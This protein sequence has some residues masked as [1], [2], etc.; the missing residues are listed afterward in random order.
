MFIYKMLLSIINGWEG[1]GKV[2]FLA[3]GVMVYERGNFMAVKQTL[4]SAHR[5]ARGGSLSIASCSKPWK[6]QRG[7]T[8]G[9]HKFLAV[10]A[11]RGRQMLKVTSRQRFM[12]QVFRTRTEDRRGHP[13]SCHCSHNL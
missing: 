9:E 7:L 11:A 6:H 1:G 10:L 5:V 13:G 2:C 4:P 12:K 8:S 3:D